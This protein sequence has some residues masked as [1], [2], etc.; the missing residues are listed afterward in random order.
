[1]ILLKEIDQN[2]RFL[3]SEVTKQIRA[4]EKQIISQDK[5]RLV[6]VES[7]EGYIDVLKNIIE[8]KCFSRL[9]TT[10]EKDKTAINI[11]RAVHTITV[12]LERI[13]DFCVNIMR[14]FQYFDDP[15]F[16][17]ARFDTG[18]FLEEILAAM[19]VT[20]D[21]L[22]HSDNA[23][24]MKICRAEFRTDRLYKDCFSIIITEMKEGK[25][26]T[27][28]QNLI[29]ALFIFRYLERIGDSLLNIGEAII[30][31]ILG[32]KLKIHQ[33]EALEEGLEKVSP[34]AIDGDIGFSS[35]AETRSG[36]RIGLVQTKGSESR[37][38]GIIFKDGKADKI[39][40]EKAGID[41]WEAL[42]PGL[43]PK[44]FD[45]QDHGPA[46]SILLECLSGYTFQHILI[47][48]P[49]QMMRKIAG[50]L[51]RRCEEIWDKTQKPNPISAG[52]IRQLSARLDDVFHL[53]PGCR[54]GDH[55]IGESRFPGLINLLESIATI[56]EHLACPFSVFV[57]GDFNVD[58]IIWDPETSRIHYID[59]HRSTYHDYLQDISVF[60]V[61]IFRLPPPPQ[62][63]L[64]FVNE[65]MVGFLTF[66]REYAHKHD[67]RFFEVRLALGL[68]R[69]FITSARFQLNTDSALEMIRRGVYLLRK[70]WKHNPQSYQTF[71]LF[72]DVLAP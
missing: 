15:G 21:A 30:S 5:E 23:L 69:S 39:R 63:R 40:K 44:I 29:T 2:Y 6:K 3:V 19:A 55:Y 64:P 1:M 4:V 71:R 49:P 36:C 17:A 41:Q 67:D 42:V 37:G 31:T 50:E 25:H 70:I 33:Y 53:H 45:F 46:A 61:S 24:A 13:G 34:N 18:P 52:F 22:F 9:V 7:R 35:I 38:H 66:C 65:V 58:N 47:N 12:N 59:L 11:T 10:E 26:H 14:Q 43:P 27:D 28:I 20:N 16:L 48:E 57:H 54:D 62:D 8:N 68:A 72:D 56:E 32:E 60:L 51:H